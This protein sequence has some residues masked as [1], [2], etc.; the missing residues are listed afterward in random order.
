MKPTKKKKNT[1]I[2]K[3]LTFMDYSLFVNNKMMPISIVTMNGE[4]IPN[5]SGWFPCKE[6]PN[7]AALKMMVNYK[8]L[9][10]IMGEKLAGTIIEYL[11]KE[12]FEPVLILFST[13]DMAWPNGL[14]NFYERLNHAS[15][16]DLKKQ[17]A[18]RQKYIDK[19]IQKQK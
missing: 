19:I 4:N 12:T 17:R 2:V 7:P 13:N 3:P 9:K 18:I 1:Y 10:P 8:K 15:R 16:Q 14:V 5:P 6:F 11:D